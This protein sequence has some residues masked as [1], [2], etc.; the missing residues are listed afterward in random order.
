MV[1]LLTSGN[2]K[3]LMKKVNAIVESV[4]KHTPKEGW[5]D[6]LPTWV[7]A[8]HGRGLL[9]WGQSRDKKTG[10]VVDKAW[11]VPKIQRAALTAAITA[12]MDFVGLP[13]TCAGRYL[14]LTP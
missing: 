3:A 11:A 1:S 4:R 9:G 13:P 10:Q 5:V 7:G 6:H 8:L 12:W 2:I 14:T